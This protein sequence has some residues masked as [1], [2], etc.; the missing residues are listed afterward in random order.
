MASRRV[1]KVWSFRESK[2]KLGFDL[3][4]FVGDATDMA[5]SEVFVDL[6]RG[7]VKNRLA[8]HFTAADFKLLS[9]PDI[10]EGQSA[11]SRP[12]ALSIQRGLRL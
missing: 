3:K 12:P 9:S 8:C 10:T 1:E 7:P 6:G 2:S 5:G 11:C 4:V